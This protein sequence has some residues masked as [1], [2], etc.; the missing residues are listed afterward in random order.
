AD[1]ADA[2]VHDLLA[3]CAGHR[4]RRCSGRPPRRGWNGDAGM[5]IVH[6]MHHSLPGSDGYSIRAKYLLEAQVALGH[7]ITV[8]T[9]PGQGVGAPDAT[10]HGVT[11]LR[12]HYAD[13]E[14]RGIPDAA[15][16][17]VIGRAIRRRL[18]R[19]LDDRPHDIVHGHTPFTVALPAM[20]E[21]RRR[22]IPFV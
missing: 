15:K 7:E 2:F 12:S 14:R 17:L 22:R 6:V 1:F 20:R 21:A 19:L 13:W 5:K 3:P 10:I 11:Y 9:S 18:A 4:C 16:H 8:L